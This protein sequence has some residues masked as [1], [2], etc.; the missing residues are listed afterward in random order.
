MPW[1]FNRICVVKEAISD[2]LVVSK[3]GGYGVT[4]HL[5]VSVSLSAGDR[6]QST[7]IIQLKYV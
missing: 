7:D 1:I 2:A 5:V 6:R 4:P 3:A